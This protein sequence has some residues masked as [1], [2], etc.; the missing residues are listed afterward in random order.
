MI[1]EDQFLEMPLIFLGFEFVDEGGYKTVVE[2]TIYHY[3]DTQ[4]NTVLVEMKN[5][6]RACGFSE[7]TINERILADG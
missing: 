3:Y 2:K 7:D 6:L 4:I 1:A 5:F